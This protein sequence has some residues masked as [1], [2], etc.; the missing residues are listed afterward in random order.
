[1][2]CAGAHRPELGL[3]CYVIAAPDGD[4]SED[5]RNIDPNPAVL[6]IPYSSDDVPAGTDYS[7]QRTQ[8]VLKVRKISYDHFR[9]VAIPQIGSTLIES[10]FRGQKPW[11]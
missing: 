5:T 7:T 2:L 6:A 10:S 1:M 8:Y 4:L 9:N 11:R 3:A